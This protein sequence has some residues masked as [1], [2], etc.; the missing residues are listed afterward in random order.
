MRISPS[1]GDPDLGPGDRLAD[2]ADPVL[3]GPVHD[4][5]G[6]RL[7]EAVALEDHE[8]DVV[9]EPGDPRRERRRRRRCRAAAGRRS[10][11]SPSRR[12]WGRRASSRRRGRS[13]PR[14][15]PAPSPVTQ[16]SNPSIAIR[17]SAP[18]SP[19][20]AIPLRDDGVVGL[21]EDARHRRH[22]RRPH[23]ARRCRRSSRATRRT[24]APSRRDPDRLDHLGEGVG[25]RQE[26]QDHVLGED[27]LRSARP[28]APRRPTPSGSGRRPS[29]SRWCRR[30]R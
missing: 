28:P 30:C 3:P 8:P 11:P 9:E 26:E 15:A 23:L 25:H 16:A 1:V 10:A 6:G 4:R 14:G 22:H 29:G 5:P 24:R 18:L 20:S 17:K 12:P 19:C 7:G 27:E 13:R 2:R 21:L